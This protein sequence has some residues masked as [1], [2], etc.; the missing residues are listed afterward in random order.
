MGW[1][2]TPRQL[3]LSLCTGFNPLQSS[4]DGKLYRL[5][6]TN[7]KMKIWMVLDATPVPAKQAFLANEVN[8]TCNISPITLTHYQQRIIRH[9]LTD[10]RKE[11][12]FQVRRSPFAIAGINIKSVEL[13][14]MLFCEVRPGYPLNLYARSQRPST[15]SFNIFSFLGRKRSK[16][17]IK[18]T[19]VIVL[20]VELIMC[21]LQKSQL[22]HLVPLMFVRK[23]N[24]D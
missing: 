13:I 9:R 16:K 2:I 24:V 6:I 1:K 4:F 11:L 18:G 15:L 3:V 7:F 20:P 12:S 5:V 10:N 21:S 23:G 17:I 8:R 14:P 19:V 22:T